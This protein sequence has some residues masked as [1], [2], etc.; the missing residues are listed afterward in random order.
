VRRETWEAQG[1]SWLAI[2]VLA[3]LTAGTIGTSRD[4]D[5]KRPLVVMGAFPGSFDAGTAFA[6]EAQKRMYDRTSDVLASLHHWGRSLPK[7]PLS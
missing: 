6:P 4:G 7:Q 3:D 2:E 5:D 1:Q